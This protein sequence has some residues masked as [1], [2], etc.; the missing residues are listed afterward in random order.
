MY[1]DITQYNECEQR[2]S[3]YYTTHHNQDH[4][5]RGSIWWLNFR[6]VHISLTYPKQPMQHFHLVN[7]HLSG[8]FITRLDLLCSRVKTAA[9]QCFDL[10]Y[11]SFP[12]TDS[13]SR[14]KRH[15]I[16]HVKTKILFD[17]L[18]HYWPWNKQK[19]KSLTSSIIDEA[20]ANCVDQQGCPKCWP[21][22]L[23]RHLTQSGPP[24]KC[25]NIFERAQQCH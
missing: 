22:C 14:W 7:Y 17:I 9:L 11:K 18:L 5:H 10:G 6:I 15:C 24:G 25:S 8:C 19:K 20:V 4:Y 2:S 3:A 23:W 12:R 1:I 13:F 21:F 16:G